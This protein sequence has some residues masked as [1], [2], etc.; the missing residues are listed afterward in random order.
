[1]MKKDFHPANR[2]NQKRIW[3]K[4]QEKK[5]KEEKEADMRAQYAREQDLFQNKQLLGNEKAKVGLSFMYEP[6]PGARKQD[7]EAKEA[8]TQ[9]AQAEYKF[10]WQRKY[11]APREEIAKGNEEVRDQPFGI[12]VRNVRCIKCHQ[13]GHVNTQRICP[14]FGISKEEAAQVGI[15][16]LIQ[17]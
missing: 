9:A 5:L 1:M 14:M 16:Q 12:E 13:W 11:N 8:A 4:E 2:E 6:P 3:M 7:I 15:Y 17:L 10:E